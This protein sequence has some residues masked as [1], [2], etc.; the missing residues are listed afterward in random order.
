M[1][2]KPDGS[3]FSKRVHPEIFVVEDLNFED[4]DR[5]DRAIHRATARRDFTA[6]RMETDSRREQNRRR[7]KPQEGRIAEKSRKARAGRRKIRR[8]T[9]RRIT[10]VFLL[11][12][13]LVFVYVLVGL[14]YRKKFFPNTWVNGIDVSGK[15]AEGAEAEVFSAMRSYS[16]TLYSR[17]NPDEKI[18]GSEVGLS[19]QAEETLAALISEQNPLAWGFHLMRTDEYSSVAVAK[20]G[21]ERLHA[22]LETLPCMQ[23]KFFRNPVDAKISEYISG[24][25][26]TVTEE[27]PGTA[28]NRAMAEETIKSALCTLRPELDLESAEVY[29]EPQVFSDDPVLKRALAQANRCVSSQVFYGEQGQDILLDGEV[30]SAWIKVREDGTFALDDEGISGFVSE[31]SKR[32]DSCGEA[33]LFKSSWGQ[34][35]TVEGGDYGWQIDKAAEAAWLR[36]SLPRGIVIS[37]MP[38]FLKQAATHDMADYGTTYIEVNLTAHHLYYYTDGKEIVSSDFKFNNVTDEKNVPTGIYELT[39]SLEDSS[40]KEGLSYPEYHLFFNKGRA[41]YSIAGKNMSGGS[42]NQADEG[43]G[44]IELPKDTADKLFQH[45]GKGTPIILYRLA[46]TETKRKAVI[47]SGSGGA[48]SV[49]KKKNPVAASKPSIVAGQANNGHGESAVVNGGVQQKTEGIVQPGVSQDTSQET[50]EI[51]PGIP[52]SGRK[53]EKGPGVP[54]AKEPTNE[55]AGPGTSPPFRAETGKAPTSEYGPGV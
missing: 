48:S 46:G 43:G 52:G 38:V 47:K 16:L 23:E 24:K 8:K 11:L 14:S 29:I 41:L 55:P 40:L 13:F 3:K 10:C 6:E 44:E 26:Y 17:E 42:S 45:V 22:L 49:Q 20:P 4:T 37:R 18:R 5:Q 19:C 35:V 36:E 25:G 50:K 53:E 15:T 2:D 31:L 28:L 30:I 39:D 32:Y 12:L 27:I 33:R 51:G 9:S 34:E 1:R 21:E 54:A 7:E